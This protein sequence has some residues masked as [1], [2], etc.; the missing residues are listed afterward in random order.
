[1]KSS[2]VVGISRVKRY[3]IPVDNVYQRG[4]VC[5]PMALMRTPSI[6]LHPDFSQSTRQRNAGRY[7]TQQQLITQSRTNCADAR[8]LSNLPSGELGVLHAVYWKKSVPEKTSGNCRSRL[9]KARRRLRRGQR[10]QS[11]MLRNK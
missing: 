3:K 2:L 5:S 7:S 9:T 10:K 8:L 6:A 11:L 4:L 1:M